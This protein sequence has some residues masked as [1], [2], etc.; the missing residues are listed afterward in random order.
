MTI[1]VALPLM[2]TFTAKI[3][4]ELYVWVKKMFFILVG[5]CEVS[6]RDDRK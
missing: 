4:A 3:P 6:E 5:H 1:W 2:Y